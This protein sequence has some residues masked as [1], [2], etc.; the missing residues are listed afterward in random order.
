MPTGEDTHQS[1]GYILTEPTCGGLIRFQRLT[2]IRQCE[3]APAMRFGLQLPTSTSTILYTHKQYP[4]TSGITTATWLQ[5]KKTS[6]RTPSPMLSILSQLIAAM[7]MPGSY[8]LYRDMNNTN[9]HG[10][11]RLTSGRRILNPLAGFTKSE[12]R[13]QVVAFCR[14]F[15]FEDKEE[16]FYHGALAAQRPGCHDDIEELTLEEKTF[17]RREVTHKWHL[18]K[19][20]YY[21]IALCSLGSA[22]QGWDNTGAN[23]ANLS[24]PQE[25]G[26][27][28]NEWLIGVINAVSASTAHAWR[29]MVLD[30]RSYQNVTMQ[31]ATMRCPVGTAVDMVHHDRD[32]RCLACYQPGRLIPSTMPSAAEAPSS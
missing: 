3:A 25:F 12:L 5:Q 24:F 19:H 29:C 21:T 14:D 31:E 9:D 10:T 1:L 30:G 4:Q 15:G 26:I 20:L 18:P 32:R 2:I 13:T 11:L 28:D 6:S 17:L 27:A 7:S 8:S 22:I 16:V 23:G